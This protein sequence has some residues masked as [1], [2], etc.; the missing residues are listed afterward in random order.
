[1]QNL[2]RQVFLLA[3]VAVLFSRFAAAEA[4]DGKCVVEELSVPDKVLPN[5]LVYVNMTFEN[6]GTATWTRQTVALYN[7]LNANTLTWSTNPVPLFNADKIAPGQK[8]K[9]RFQISGT[10]PTPRYLGLLGVLKDISTGSSFGIACE[11]AVRVV[12]YVNATSGSYEYPN[13]IATPVPSTIEGRYAYD[14]VLPFTNTGYMPWV[15]DKIALYA[16]ASTNVF[17]TA[18]SAYEKTSLQYLTAADNI[19]L[20]YSKAFTATIYPPRN[21]SS[22]ILRISTRM[23]NTGYSAQG[24][25]G[26]QKDL[27]V[28][29]P[30]ATP[31]PSPPSTSPSPSP[32]ATTTVIPA[33][34]ASYWVNGTVVDPTG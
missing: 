13:F 34:E 8:K 22:Y 19:S 6:T 16:N 11:S 28:S 5:Q 2:G 18:T 33:P 24:F 4:Y 32:T 17:S 23:K 15:K 26:E 7:G 31:T 9:F 30:A 29:I 3:L 21:D 10:G 1:M 20:G 12:A 14:L 25:F 27:L